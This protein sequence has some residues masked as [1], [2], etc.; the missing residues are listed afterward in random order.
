MVGH[1]KK[2]LSIVGSEIQILTANGGVK[3]KGMCL[4]DQYMGGRAAERGGW[5]ASPPQF[6]PNLCK[7]SLFCHKFWHFY[8]Y[9]P[10]TFQLAPL[11]SNSLRRLCNKCQSSC[12]E[13]PWDFMLNKYQCL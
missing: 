7:I 2:Y 13:F 5:G 4:K 9:R 10:L 8:A 11:L 1:H 3:E 12:L 6:L